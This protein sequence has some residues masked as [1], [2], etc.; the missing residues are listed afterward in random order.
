[1]RKTDFQIGNECWIAGPQVTVDCWIRA[2][3]VRCR[4][5][6]S[7]AISGSHG[8]QEDDDVGFGNAECVYAIDISTTESGQPEDE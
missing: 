7:G 1:M 4:E 5:H 6:S 8:A 3:N 2:V